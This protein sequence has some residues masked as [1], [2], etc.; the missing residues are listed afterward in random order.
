VRVVCVADLHGHLPVI[1]PCD[2][3]V[4]AGDICPTGDER[5]V[6]QRHWLGSTFAR[7]L[8]EVPARAIVGVAGNHDVIGESDPSVLRN[9]DW[10]YLQDEGVEIAGLSV[11]GSP[12]TSRFQD[13]A[14]MLTE[15]QLAE[16]WQRIPPSTDVLCVHSPPLGY[17]DRIGALEFGSPSLLAA[18]DERAPSLC[19]FGHVHAGFGRWQRG[20]SLLVNAAYCDMQ[21]RPAHEPVIVDLD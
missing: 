21:Y 2:L 15:Q 7:W 19:V 3:L 18:I 4:V 1:P 5:P 8:A 14:F 12:W 17:G 11:Y 16:R 20:S 10:H 9:L 6:T 13:W